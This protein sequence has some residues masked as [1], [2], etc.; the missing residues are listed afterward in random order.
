[1]TSADVRHPRL[2]R[3]PK[4]HQGAR[5][6]TQA[7]G[8][9]PHPPPDQPPPS[10]AFSP[11]ESSLP[12]EAPSE[13][14]RPHALLDAQADTF[15]L[16]SCD[17]P[18]FDLPTT[19]QLETRGTTAPISTPP[20]SHCPPATQPEFWAAQT[21]HKNSIAA[22]LREAGLNDLAQGLEDC[23]SQFTYAVCNDCGRVA[24]FPNRCDRFYCP[25][26]QPRLAHDRKE[27]VQ[28]WTTLVTQPKHVVLTVR[29]VPELTKAHVRE[30]QSWLEALRRRAFCRK[31][32]HWWEDP[33]AMAR[34]HDAARNGAPP[35]LLAALYRSAR[36]PIPEWKRSQGSCY[37]VSSHPWRGGF[38][39]IELTKEG[40]GWHLH[41]HLLIDSDYIDAIE[42][43]RQWCDVTRGAGYIVKVKDARGNDY[44]REVTKY[45]VK[46]NQLAEWSGQDIVTFIQ[47]FTGVRTFGVFG[48]LYKART[49]F[50]E[51][52]ASLRD[53]KPKCECGSCNVSY[54]DEATFL[55]FDLVPDRPAVAPRPP[56]PPPEPE[57]TLVDKDNIPT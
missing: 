49:Q 5:P 12:P 31:A 44:L 54:Y 55:K 37:T 29:N 10:G 14:P 21:A 42:L 39:S 2:L 3:G 19:I 43:S 27:A 7:P 20:P 33:N 40:N 9:Q 17:H 38:W 41:Y 28:W 51:F 32:R 48:T 16:A 50:A 23:H 22:K 11:L 52:I 46:G 4:G 34:Y 15:D 25:E 57:F 26:C 36:R 45:A 18:R 6:A 30:F 24:T 13:D 1:M 53:A 56:P 35:Q 47:A 8:A